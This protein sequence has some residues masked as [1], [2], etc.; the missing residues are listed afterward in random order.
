MKINN[1]SVTSLSSLNFELIPTKPVCILRGHNSELALDL[2][3]E[4]IGDFES[5]YY[6]IDCVGD[7]RFIIHSDVEIDEKN[8]SVC[9]IRNADYIGDNRLAANFEPNS[10]KF[11]EDDTYEFIEKRKKRNKNASN[12]IL[13]ISELP[14]NEDD[15][16]LFVYQLDREDEAG[17]EAFVEK[18][19]CTG[20]QVFVSVCKGFPDI[21]QAD[22]QIITLE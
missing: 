14:A 1:L 8:Y 16:P 3:R 15:R 18:L 17:I 11:S 5:D 10:I 4:L 20:R 13:G 7:G 9:Y 12:I 2:I 19:A 6:D 21:K 22:T